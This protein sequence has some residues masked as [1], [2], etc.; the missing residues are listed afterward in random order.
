MTLEYIEDV[1]R[2]KDLRGKEHEEYE[3]LLDE[4]MDQD[5]AFVLW[6]RLNI[7]TAVIF[8]W[9]ILFTCLIFLFALDTEFEVPGGLGQ[10]LAVLT[11]ID[12]PLFMFFMFMSAKHGRELAARE[13]RVLAFLES[14]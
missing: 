9:C 14:C 11:I 8:F 3:R 5:G 13:A 6:H 2:E 12:F 10:G 1:A 7:V 4:V